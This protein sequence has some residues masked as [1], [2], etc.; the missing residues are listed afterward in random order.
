LHLEEQYRQCIVLVGAGLVGTEDEIDPWGTGFLVAHD[1]AGRVVYLV[2]A[3][4]VISDRVDAPFDIRFNK[5]AVA[6]KITASIIQLGFF[7]LRTIPWTWR[8]IP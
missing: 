4:H 5:R 7:T 2:T 8:F 6:Q 3:A 1:S